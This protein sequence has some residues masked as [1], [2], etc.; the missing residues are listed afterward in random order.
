MNRMEKW[1]EIRKSGDFTGYA[2]KLGVDPAIVRIMYNREIPETH[3]RE[4]L[5]GG[6][7]CLHAPLA[8]RDMDKIISILKSKVDEGKKIRII[9]DY[10]IDGVC[11]TYLLKSCLKRIGA[12]VDAV[13]PDRIKDGYG[14]NLHLIENAI[15][16]GRDTI[17]TCD[18]GISAVEQIT[19]AKE[20]GMTVLVTDHHESP[21]ELPPAD[22]IVD[23]KQKDCTYPFPGICGT[24]VVYKLMERLYQSMGIDEREWKAFLEIAAFATI[25]DVME[26]RD[27]NRI[28]VKH[29]LRE[30]KETKNIG[31]RA[32]IQACELEDREITPYHVGFVLGPCMNATGRLDTA[33]KALELL[34]CEDFGKA[35]LIA[36]E[37]LK[38][39]E[40]RKGMTEKYQKLAMEQVEE[41]EWKEDT[42]YVVYLPECHE[43][44]AGIIAGRVRERY[45]RPVFVLTDGEN[46]VKGSGRS[47][48]EYHMYE[49]LTE[50][51]ELL[52]QYGGHKLAAGLSLK[53]E[54]IDILRRRLNSNSQLSKDDLMEKVR[55]D[56]ELPFSYLS[57]ELIQQLRFLEPCGNGNTKPVF[58]ARG[59]TIDGGQIIGKNQNVYRGIAKDQSGKAIDFVYFGEVGDFQNAINRTKTLL[60]TYYPE[61]NCYKNRKNI[62]IIIQK[63]K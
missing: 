45:S 4:Y 20:Q 31:L 22:A 15:R 5:F 21:E 63:Y 58:A 62:Q 35:S 37:L 1:V 59:V 61:I 12:D 44:L 48:E 52:L 40:Q 29:G 8:M 47:I 3:M 49:K 24:V 7:E 54:N 34:E 16:D 11:A 53:K 46:N 27:E 43:S 26:L 28:L 57:E 18:N 10:D 36:S 19:F 38:L 17:I 9:G 60:I 25:G 39:N 56:M 50:V 51:K 41:S 33:D 30:L 13:I 2:Q 14:L 6:L 23:P 32:L 42:V 55:I